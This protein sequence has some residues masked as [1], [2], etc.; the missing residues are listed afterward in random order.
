MPKKQHQKRVAKITTVANNKYL[1]GTRTLTLGLAGF[2]LGQVFP[3]MKWITL[4]W[5]SWLTAF[6]FVCVWWWA[7]NFELVHTYIWNRIHSIRKRWA[8]IIISCI[9]LFFSSGFAISYINKKNQTIPLEVQEQIDAISK[10]L[11]ERIEKQYTKE[12][13]QNMSQGGLHPYEWTD[14]VRRV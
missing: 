13:L 7:I 9:T 3:Q 6:G 12:Q 4:E 1:L 8:V 2:I 10:L 5:A 11:T 14:R